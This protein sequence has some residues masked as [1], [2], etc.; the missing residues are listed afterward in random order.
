MRTFPIPYCA[1]D[2][3]LEPE[4]VENSNSLEDAH[5]QEELD[6]LQDGPPS[7]LPP[8][9]PPKGSLYVRSF[10]RRSLAGGQV[11]TRYSVSDPGHTS[12]AASTS[13]HAQVAEITYPRD[14]CCYWIDFIVMKTGRPRCTVER[15]TLG[16]WTT[17]D[18]I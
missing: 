16:N 2:S 13:T 10:P 12:S 18:G 1:A 7:A 8:P 5:T 9:L 3:D 17:T 14:T 6:E 15:F 4:A 11:R